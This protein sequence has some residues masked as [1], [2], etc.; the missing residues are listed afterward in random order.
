MGP[1]IREEGLAKSWQ[2]ET[3]YREIERGKIE[4][5]VEMDVIFSSFLGKT[6]A[7]NTIFFIFLKLID[8]LLSFKT[9]ETSG[10]N[11]I[12]N[13]LQLNNIAKIVVL[14]SS[15]KT[16]KNKTKHV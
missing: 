11:Q 7:K 8:R 3:I 16:S 5:K 13:F 9:Q 2:S 15:H 4:K 14:S 12:Y 6:E 10:Q 1:F